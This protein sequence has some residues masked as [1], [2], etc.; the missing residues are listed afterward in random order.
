MRHA[1]ALRW[2]LAAIACCLCLVQSAAAQ[3]LPGGDWAPGPGAAGDNTYGG[4]IDQPANGA[5]I[6]AGA[7]FH[8]SGWVVDSSA[9][10]WAGIDGVQVMLG[11]TLL[12]HGTVGI[13]RPDV[14]A[15]LNNPF[16]AQSGFDAVVAGGVPAGAQTLTVVAHTPGKGSWTK[17]VSV[18]IT[19]SAGL[20]TAP[21][22]S[23]TGLVFT[24]NTPGVNESILANKNGVINGTAYDTR[25]RPELGSGVDRVQTYLDGPRGQPGSQFL[26]E[27]TGFNTT[28]SIPWEPTRF[29]SVQHHALY[30]YA[31]SA[32][33]GEEVLVNREFN[34]VPR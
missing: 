12:A 11:N 8:V 4:F 10:G 23:G 30:A 20:S 6:A 17:N 3:Q 22:T 31:R 5:N 13:N 21:N 19:G 1:G 29:D 7:S 16:F 27:A 9:E 33:T 24:I 28:W 34:I 25:T 15:A 18:N 2:V 14:A 32:V 26:G